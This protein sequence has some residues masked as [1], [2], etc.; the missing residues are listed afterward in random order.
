MTHTAVIIV[1]EVAL[2]LSKKIRTLGT[3]SDFRVR[4]SLLF[5]VGLYI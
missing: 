4:M 3:E 5:L 2:S 1:S